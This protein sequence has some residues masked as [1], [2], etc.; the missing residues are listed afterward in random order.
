MRAEF[1]IPI[2]AYLLGAIPFGF[3]LVRVFQES[4]I[5]QTGSG[6]IGATNVYRKSKWAGIL[7][8]LL[9]GGKGYLAVMIAAWLGAGRDWQAA[10][11]LFAILGHVFTVF[12]GFK[13]GKGVATGCGA[14]L[15]VSPPAVGCALAVFV[16]TVVVSRYISL[17]SILGTAVF[18][19]WSVVFGEPLAVVGWAALGGI[20]IIVKHQSNIRRLVAG[21]E[22]KFALRG[23]S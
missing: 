14:F 16:L 9:D 18:P 23:G 19:V 7:T 21:T 6:N 1:A 17:A 8:L 3:V 12:L 13:G 22:N 11:A 15:A 20:V 10:A 5:R 4:D 2:V